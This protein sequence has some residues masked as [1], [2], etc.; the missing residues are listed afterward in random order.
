MLTFRIFAENQAGN[1]FSLVGES[2]LRGHDK[3]ISKPYC[4]SSVRFR[5]FAV[6]VIRPWND[7]PQ[8][9][10]SA[11]SLASFKTRL[12]CFLD[13]IKWNTILSLLLCYFVLYMCIY[14]IVF[15]FL[16]QSSVLHHF[17]YTSVT[18][19]LWFDQ[20][21]HPTEEPGILGLILATRVS[22]AESLNRWQRAFCTSYKIQGHVYCWKWVQH[23]LARICASC[24]ITLW[25]YILLLV[26]QRLFSIQK[27]LS[28][29]SRALFSSFF[30]WT[31]AGEWWVLVSFFR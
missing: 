8:D 26:Y 15:E 14:A 28:D 9:I 27:T 4:H 30:W 24:S 5:S 22:I 29:V 19:W 20:F 21:K 17:L 16:Y 12:D 1:F 3:K 25:T 31:E 23:M 10:D 13:L 11:P 7:L 6:R 2:S 18:D